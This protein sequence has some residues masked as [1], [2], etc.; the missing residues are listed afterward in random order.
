MFDYLALGALIS[1]AAS[2]VQPLPESPPF[3]D[4]SSAGSIPSADD[5]IEVEWLNASGELITRDA[6]RH[7]EIEESDD[8]LTDAP[9][10]S[11]R[12]GQSALTGPPGS[13]ATGESNGSDRPRGGAVLCVHGGLS[14]AV[15]TVDKIRL[16]DRK[17]EVPHEGAM[18]D[19]L[20]SDPDGTHY[21]EMM[22]SL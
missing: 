12:L 1:G 2:S 6:R 5:D 4:P 17:Q 13:G 8:G 20:W 21:H 10:G 22:K 7:G 14:P 16:L 19:L 18:C 15:D 3:A 9:A 11:P